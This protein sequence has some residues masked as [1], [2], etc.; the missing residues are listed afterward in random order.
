MG[1]R[2]KCKRLKTVKK[3]YTPAL[4][5]VWKIKKILPSKITLKKCKVGIQ[6]SRFIRLSKSAVVKLRG[7][8]FEPKSFAES[9]AYKPPAN[10][11]CSSKKI[12]AY[13]LLNF[14]PGKF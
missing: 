2:E 12:L 10:V 14:C 13:R 6:I 11:Q 3:K 4:S 5:K 7:L 9:R 8:F 1:R